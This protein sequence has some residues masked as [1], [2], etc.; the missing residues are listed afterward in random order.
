MVSGISSKLGLVPDANIA[1]GGRGSDRSVTIM[2]ATNQFGTATITITVT[3]PGGASA[4]NAF[5]LTVNPVNDLPT[6]SPL[7]DQVTAENTPTAAL[8]FTVED[9]ETPAASLR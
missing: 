3:E 1:F 6:I 5:V 2:P 4:T 7:A 8:H 9:V